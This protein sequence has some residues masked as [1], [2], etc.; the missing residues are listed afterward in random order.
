MRGTW[1]LHA[2]SSFPCPWSP[3]CVDFGSEVIKTHCLPTLFAIPHGMLQCEAW[4]QSL[5]SVRTQFRPHRVWPLERPS[6]CPFER[7]RSVQI[8]WLDRLKKWY[9][10]LG[11]GLL[12][13]FELLCNYLVISDDIWRPWCFTFKVAVQ[14]YYTCASHE[15]FQW[16]LQLI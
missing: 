12:F 4:Q 1:N 15:A 9:Q 16:P 3:H 6:I 11:F 8:Q 13:F 10:W 2:W 14:R 7:H 5:D